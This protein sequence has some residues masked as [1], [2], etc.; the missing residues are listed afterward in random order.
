[1]FRSI[2]IIHHYNLKSLQNYVEETNFRI[3]VF[4]NILCSS[5]EQLKQS[6]IQ[7]NFIQGLCGT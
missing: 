3:K 4:E 1:M 5:N 2:I 7:E 6:L